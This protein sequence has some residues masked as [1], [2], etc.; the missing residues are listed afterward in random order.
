MTALWQGRLLGAKNELNSRTCKQ[1]IP[2][3]VSR[4]NKVCV[5][6]GGGGVLMSHASCLLCRHGD[7]EKHFQESI[8]PMI[9]SMKSTHESVPFKYSVVRLYSTFMLNIVYRRY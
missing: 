9:T 3:T 6:G 8:F 1:S 4:K 2:G 5:C 7:P